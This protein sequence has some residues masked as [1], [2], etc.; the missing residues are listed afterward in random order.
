M[1]LKTN[2]MGST[3]S[4][5]VRKEKLLIEKSLEEN[6]FAPDGVDQKWEW[7]DPVSMGDKPGLLS[8]SVTVKYIKVKN[9]F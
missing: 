2:K 6:G 3:Y 7:S 1:S 4:E 8:I 9:N 5:E